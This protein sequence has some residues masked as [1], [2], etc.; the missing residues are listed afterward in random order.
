MGRHFEAA[1]FR[2]QH[3]LHPSARHTRGWHPKR[4]SEGDDVH[5][6]TTILEPGDV[7]FMP[8]GVVHHTEVLSKQPSISQNVFFNGWPEIWQDRERD[9][10][11][12][13]MLT[14]TR[15]LTRIRHDLRWSPETYLTAVFA[16]THWYLEACLEGIVP[17]KKKLRP[18]PNRATNFVKWT[19]NEFFAPETRREASSDDSLVIPCELPKQVAKLSKH[20][21]A[22]GNACHTWLAAPRASSSRCDPRGADDS[23]TCSASHL[24]EDARG[25]EADAETLR[26][27]F[28][29]NSLAQMLHRMLSIEGETPMGAF[30]WFL[31]RFTAGCTHHV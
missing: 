28:V 15:Q 20:V 8:T 27:I 25:I 6:S 2:Y 22:I 12:S 31:T 16:T 18:A 7:L 3:W 1:G 29:G 14:L 11:Q 4:I 9:G 10:D 21:K 24:Q 30:V 23:G 19:L 26:S 5:L 13:L 17:T